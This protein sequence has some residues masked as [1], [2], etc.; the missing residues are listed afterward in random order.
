MPDPVKKKKKVQKKPSN[1]QGRGGG[2]TKNTAI[3]GTRANTQKAAKK[4]KKEQEG[5]GPQNRIGIAPKK[6][7]IV[8]R[9]PK[10]L[11]ADRKKRATKIINSNEKQRLKLKEAKRKIALKKKIVRRA[12]KKKLKGMTPQRPSGSKLERMINAANKKIVAGGGK[13]MSVSQLRKA[14]KINF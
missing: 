10:K 13:P 11:P 8:R 1:M 5:Y 14:G 3:K 12:P 4:T 9:G 2:V 7:K 6:K